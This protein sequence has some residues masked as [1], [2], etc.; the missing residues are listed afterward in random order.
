MNTVP[1]LGELL[2]HLT[3]LVDAGATDVYASMGLSTYKPRYTPVM[4]A[5]AEGAKTVTDITQHSRL[6]QGAISQTVGMMV[7][8]RLVERYAL[9]DARKSGIRLTSKGRGLRQR[10]LPHWESTFEAIGDLEAEIGHPLLDILASAVRA[11]EQRGFSDRLRD[12]KAKS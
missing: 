3:D 10:L 7:D 2:R 8:D 5:L 4:R 12:A 9:D 6:T 1:G 11:L